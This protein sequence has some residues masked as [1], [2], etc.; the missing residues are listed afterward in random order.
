MLRSSFDVFGALG[1]LGAQTLSSARLAWTTFGSILGS[2]LDLKGD[3]SKVIF[4]IDFEIT[5]L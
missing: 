5:F 3:I 4:L 2:L 1:G